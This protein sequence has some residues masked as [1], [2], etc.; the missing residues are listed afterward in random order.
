MQNNSNIIFLLFLSQDLNIGMN[1]ERVDDFGTKKYR[2]D[3]SD[4][5]EIEGDFHDIED[6]Q[7]LIISER[8][9][10]SN[11]T[12]E[13]KGHTF[14]QFFADDRKCVYCTRGIHFSV[15]ELEDDVD[16]WA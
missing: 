15:P 2:E 10:K 5:C 14:V 11:T 16:N 7:Y 1:V 9:I 13:S 8:D 3:E 6:T 4:F 12:R